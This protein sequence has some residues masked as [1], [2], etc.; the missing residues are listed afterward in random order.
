MV[1]NASPSHLPHLSH[2][3]IAS[4]PPHTHHA[5]D[6]MLTLAPHNPLQHH[7]QHSNQSTE[8]CSAVK[9]SLQHGSRKYLAKLV[10]GRL[11]K[12]S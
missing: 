11:A 9:P 1:S 5:V 8:A 7:S 10:T 12:C 4:P 3:G 2:L 6:S